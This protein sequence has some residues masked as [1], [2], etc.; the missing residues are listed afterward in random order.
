[1]PGIR[2]EAKKSAPKKV[3]LND[4]PMAKVN[5]NKLYRHNDH[6]TLHKATVIDLRSDLICPTIALMTF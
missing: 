4:Y 3:K 6:K 2:P 5:L 1:M